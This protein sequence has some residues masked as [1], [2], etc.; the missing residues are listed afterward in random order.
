M[1]HTVEALQGI[2]HAAA[3]EDQVV[4]NRAL[5]LWPDVASNSATKAMRLK[6]NRMPIQPMYGDLI[7][8]RLIRAPIRGTDQGVLDA[9]HSFLRFVRLAVRGRCGEQ[10]DRSQQRVA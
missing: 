2:D 10:I 7:A 3:F 1:H 4:G 8:K 5:F 6:E 9:P